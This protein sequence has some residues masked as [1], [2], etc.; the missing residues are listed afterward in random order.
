MGLRDSFSALET[1]IT[2]LDDALTGLRCTV[3]EDE[4]SPSHALVTAF[5]DA[6]DDLGGWL[7]DAL[8][9]VRT[10]AQAGTDKTDMHQLWRG[11]ELGQEAVNHMTHRVM[12]DLVA[13]DVVDELSR[14]GRQRGREWTSWA[15]TVRRGLEQLQAQLYDVNAKLLACWKELAERSGSTWV[16]VQATNIGQQLSVPAPELAADGL[17]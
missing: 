9:A 5:G 3:V 15:S 16:S 1:S 13:Y 6:I 7:R 11:L 10:S 17:P 8:A 14:L 12:T 4:P 2:Q